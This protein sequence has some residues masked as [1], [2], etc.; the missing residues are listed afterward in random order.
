MRTLKLALT[1]VFVSAFSL[2]AADTGSTITGTVRLEGNPPSI[3]KIDAASDADV[4]GTGLRAAR[5]LLLGSNQVVRNAIVYLDGPP[6]TRDPN[7][8]NAGVTLDQR[9]CEFV[10]RIQIAPGGAPLLIKNSDPVLHVVRIDSM[11]G[12]NAAQTL[13]QVATPY[14][15][16]QKT[17]RLANFCEPTLLQVRSVNGYEWMVAYIGVMPHPWSALTDENGRFTL[18]NVPAGRHKIYAWHEVLGTLTREV[19][20]SRGRNAAV[21]FGFAG[22]P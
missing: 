17:Y 15:G 20:V 19:R 12:T 1:L 6:Q 8:T 7:A 13:L 3:P 14:A 10:P 18:R 16:Y 5:E 21:D 11:S 4:C 22:R 2:Q 9:A